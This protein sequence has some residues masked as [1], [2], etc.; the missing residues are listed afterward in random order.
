VEGDKIFKV[1]DLV[2]LS[3]VGD[4]ELYVVGN[5]LELSDGETIMKLYDKDGLPFPR[6]DNMYVNG[7]HLEIIVEVLRD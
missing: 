7:Y 4:D 5:T 6:D 1:G 3:R 2:K